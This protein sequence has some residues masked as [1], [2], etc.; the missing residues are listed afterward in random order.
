MTMR[1]TLT[2][3][4][5]AL[6]S[7][8][9]SAV[10]MVQDALDRIRDPD[11]EGARAFVKVHAEQ[12]LAA[13]AAH[14]GLRAAGAAPSPFAGIPISVKDLF[15][16]KGEATPAG[17]KALAG[18]APAGRDA[19]AIARLKAAGF[20]VVGRTNMTEF[21]FSGLGLN[22]HYGTPA[23]PWDR[24]TRR[25]PG[26]SS[27]GAG[28]S[29]AD[30][31][32]AAGTGSDTG[33]SCRI[34]AAL[35]GTVGYKPTA[36]AVP[37]DGALPLST[38]LDS[39]GSMAPSVECCR[40]LHTIL[41]GAPL[42]AAPVRPVAGLRIAVP[43]TV[44]LDGLEPYVAD[45]FERRLK[46]LEA[47]G[48]RIVFVPLAE[49]AEV[50]AINAKGGFTAAE[51]YAWHARLAAEKGGDYD[52]RVLKRILRGRDQSAADYIELLE[53]R[54]DF[55]RRVEAAIAAYDVIAMPTVPAVAPPIAALEADDDLF[56]RVNLAMLRNPTLIN[57]MDGCSIS[58]PMHEAG[59]APAGLMLSARGGQD[60]ALFAAARAVEAALADPIRAGA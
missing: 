6:D 54:A 29:V 41:S 31:M 59:E 15:D 12:A 23:S 13:A 52:P 18:A 5:E 14:D 44:A 25:I 53:R 50:A 48:A 36:S 37:L 26:G 49:F 30:G 60:A 8:R 20:V 7:G 19:P 42:D 1:E 3:R 45:L 34:P 55:V 47:A 2:A 56:T 46:Q 11:G 35:C 28:V 51:S 4:A 33:G 9:M 38:T 17:S 24:Q 39:I 22:P 43:Q 58:L 32:A 10:Q 16:L 57:M 27:S 21:A 40:I